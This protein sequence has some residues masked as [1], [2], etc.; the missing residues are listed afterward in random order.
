[1]P[2]S[3]RGNS[4]R[5]ARSPEERDADR[6]VEMISGYA[7]SLR[8]IQIRHIPFAPY[9]MNTMFGAPAGDFCH[10]LLHPHLMGSN[11]P[12]PKGFRDLPIGIDGLYLGAPA[13]TAGPARLSST[14]RRLLGRLLSCRLT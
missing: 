6:V 8:N 14:A 2:L 13:A 11:G 1:M 4:A 12:G 10:G 7:P 9:N 5:P 3:S